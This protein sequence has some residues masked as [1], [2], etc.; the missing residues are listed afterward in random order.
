MLNSLKFSIKKNFPK[1][2]FSTLIVPEISNNKI[3]S[4]SFNLVTAAKQLDDDVN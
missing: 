3:H 1:F 4:S 2:N